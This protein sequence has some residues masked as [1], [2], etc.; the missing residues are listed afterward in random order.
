MKKS[1]I[2]KIVTIVFI[3]L[4]VLGVLSIIP[5]P[6]F[7]DFCK[8]NEIKTF[9]EH[10][11]IYKIAFYVCYLI[12]LSILYKLYDTFKYI[13]NVNPFTKKIEINLKHIAVLFMIL[14]FII[15]IKGIFI[16]T[17]LTFGI[18]AICFV[19][20]L[21]FYLLAEVIK[22]GIIYKDEVEA[23]IWLSLI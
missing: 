6:I 21:C 5:L 2:A 20:S 12:S 19:V 22:K 1:I 10:T 16:P 11:L 18:G 7:Y 4:L 15:L 23:T 13:Y 14:C 8:G 9:H 17:V 3:V